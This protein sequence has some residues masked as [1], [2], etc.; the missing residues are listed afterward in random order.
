MEKIKKSNNNKNEIKKLSF[1]LLWLFIWKL[2]I[3]IHLVFFLHFSHISLS[4][5]RMLENH[6]NIKNMKGKLI[7]ILNLNARK[8][9]SQKSFYA[10]CD[11]EV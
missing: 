4:L 5:M 11:L 7:D 8:M 9:F 6:V 3:V 10:I 1:S 2:N